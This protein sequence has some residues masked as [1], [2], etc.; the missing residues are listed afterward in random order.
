VP[1]G[2]MGKDKVTN[3]EETDRQTEVVIAQMKE[4]TRKTLALVFC[5]LQQLKGKLSKQ[6]LSSYYWYDSVCR[7]AT[8]LGITTL[9]IMSFIMTLSISN[10]WRNV[11]LRSGLFLL[12]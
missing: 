1:L 9:S 5:L 2:Q 3:V 4:Q 10:K 11:M 12:C 8:T 6:L 7:G